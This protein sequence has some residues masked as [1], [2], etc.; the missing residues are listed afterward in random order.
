MGVFRSLQTTIC[1][2]R[3]RWLF[4]KP[5]R[6]VRR[7][8]NESRVTAKVF[9][10][11]VADGRRTMRTSLLCRRFLASR[12]DRA[13]SVWTSIFSALLPGLCF[14]N[15]A[16]LLCIVPF[17][18]RFVYRCGRKNRLRRAAHPERAHY[19][20]CHEPARLREESAL[21]TSSTRTASSFILLDGPQRRGRL[22]TVFPLPL[23]AQGRKSSVRRGRRPCRRLFAVVSGLQPVGFPR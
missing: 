12:F 19:C 13:A 4:L 2:K 10:P 11:S 20:T 14:R 9:L 1:R 22:R 18:K 5:S 15:A 16:A 6:I 7:G 8:G 21:Y 17:H 3:C 23:S